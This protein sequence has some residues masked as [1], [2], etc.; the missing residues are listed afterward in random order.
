[1]EQGSG[2]GRYEENVEVAISAAQLPDKRFAAWTTEPEELADILADSASADTTVT[3][4]AQ[5]VTVT[6]TYE[7][8]YLL[9]V[10]EGSGSGSYAEG[11]TI[12]I[13]ANM[14][15]EGMEFAAWIVDPE[16]YADNLANS[17]SESTEVTMPGADLTV[18]AT[19]QEQAPT[20][21]VTYHKNS[22]KVENSAPVDPRAYEADAWVFILGN[23][24]NMFLEEHVFKGWTDDPDS[25]VVTV[26]HT[27]GETFQITEDVDL[28]AVWEN[29][30]LRHLYLPHVDGT[31]DWFTQI[32][33]VNAGNDPA[34]AVLRVI[35]DTGNQVQVCPVTL[36]AGSRVEYVSGLDECLPAIQGY[37]V[38]ETFSDGLTGYT[39]FGIEGEYR[40]AL[41]LQEAYAEAETSVPYVVSNDDQETVF[42]LVNPGNEP[43]TVEIELLAGDGKPSVKE[44][45]LAAGER[46]LFT[47]LELLQ[48]IYDEEEA[49]EERELI[50]TARISNLEGMVGYTMLRHDK[51]VQLDGMLF[52]PT[53]TSMLI[54]H[55]YGFAE[56]EWTTILVFANPSQEE[57]VEMTLSG[58]SIQSGKVDDYAVTLEPGE[59]QVLYPW[60]DPL[61]LSDDVAWLSGTSDKPVAGMVIYIVTPEG[62]DA[63]ETRRAMALTATA[64]QYLRHIASETD[65]ANWAMIPIVNITGQSGVFPVLDPYGKMDTTIVNTE[66]EPAFMTLEAVG[67][68]GAILIRTD[69]YIRGFN[70][71]WLESA[72]ELMR[73]N[74][75]NVE[76]VDMAGVRYI[77]YASTRAMSGLQINGSFDPIRE[78]TM[79][80]SLVAQL[81]PLLDEYPLTLELGERSGMFPFGRR[82]SISA[83]LPDRWQ[84]FKEW[85]GDP[86]SLDRVDNI[87]NPNTMITMPAGPITLRAVYER[88][89]STKYNLQVENGRTSGDHTAGKF[90]PVSADDVT[91]LFFDRWIGTGAPYLTRVNV[92]SPQVVMP[93]Q[94]IVIEATY[95]DTE[96][97]PRELTVLRG[98][99][100]GT[101]IYPLGRVV[102]IFAQ[103]PPTLDMMF[104]KWTGNDYPVANANLPDTRLTMPNEDIEIE[105]TFKLIPEG[106]FT[107]TVQTQMPDSASRRSSA[108]MRWLESYRTTAQTRPGEWVSLVAPEAPEGMVFDLWTGQTGY[109]EDVSSPK[110]R[111][112]MPDHNVNVVATYKESDSIQR[113]GVQYDANQGSN[114]PEDTGRY[115][116]GAEIVAQNPGDMSRADYAF[117]AWNTSADRTEARIDARE[118]QPNESFLM[119]EGGITLFAQW[120]SLEDRAKLVTDE[121]SGCFRSG[122]HTAEEF[123]TFNLTREQ[124]EAAIERMIDEHGFILDDPVVRSAAADYLAETYPPAVEPIPTLSEWGLIILSMIMLL[125]GVGYLRRQ[126]FGPRP[127]L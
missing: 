68:D 125:L 85:E 87:Y 91:E 4:P 6:A 89:G 117:M 122:C 82:V 5:D 33:L 92:P 115:L 49:A 73:K 97:T 70:K 35:D 20:Y 26:T 57:S 10:V 95:T 16:A 124:W 19:Y 42:G 114:P 83:D 108:N 78:S 81:Y 48:A 45:D 126:R 47:V 1:V 120:I 109:I 99:P 9:E 28:Y 22:E 106:D 50:E 51:S 88:K 86:W 66:S 53:G 24:G 84:I 30:N 121:T 25:E 67:E 44:I 75:E 13:S 102:R 110:T 54:P 112:Y 96:P 34:D 105:A 107:V 40:M 74:D 127:A 11:E 29:I 123:Q 71:L 38:V 18:V 76:D 7:T 2:S 94:D 8:L 39:R 113:Y 21:T 14:P 64:E 79:V 12:Q 98:R 62:A 17:E 55:I 103:L 15:D 72:Q 36:P 60:Q 111:M 77:R 104:D 27:P 59:R 58:Y 46:K 93:R 32:A 80:D 116:E 65:P 3:M 101:N 63:P 31:G 69:K 118:Y 61:N 41:P 52:T 56:D 90:I 23:S 43:K 119:P 37:V 100:S